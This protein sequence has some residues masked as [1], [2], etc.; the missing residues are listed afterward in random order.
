MR[1]ATLD[2][3]HDT[4]AG[5]GD[6]DRWDLV[7]SKRAEYIA[8]CIEGQRYR[9]LVLGSVLAQVL[10]IRPQTGCD[11]EPAH[12]WVGGKRRELLADAP[13]IRGSFRLRSGKVG[14][15]PRRQKYQDGQ[16]LRRSRVQQFEV[17]TVEGGQRSVGQEIADADGPRIRVLVG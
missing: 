17:L 8:R 10:G 15:A 9:H 2:A 11:A 4:A 12:A 3:A 6:Q 16:P 1:R 5:V 7:H 13:A 14:L